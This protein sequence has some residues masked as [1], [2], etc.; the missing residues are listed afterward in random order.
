MSSEQAGPSQAE[1]LQASQSHT[2]DEEEPSDRLLNKDKAV[3]RPL[4]QK[5]ED[6]MLQLI[7]KK[8][9]IFGRHLE[10]TQ[11]QT[12]EM[13]RQTAV[14]QQMMMALMESRQSSRTDSRRGRHFFRDFPVTPYQNQH[15]EELRRRQ[16]LDRQEGTHQKAADISPYRQHNQYTLEEQM[17]AAR[18]LCQT[19]G[20]IDISLTETVI[21]LK[22]PVD[23]Q[24]PVL[25]GKTVSPLRQT[26]EDSPQL[27][28]RFT[29]RGP[30]IEI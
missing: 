1:A 12:E 20:H 11:C 25:I 30:T 19:Q 28:G 17:E 27:S 26:I 7:D 22:R 23:L 15:E 6:S 16:V 9:D 10:E 18:S 24:L 2:D 13:Q 4:F 8:L 3:F 29:Y 21:P 5:P 14:N